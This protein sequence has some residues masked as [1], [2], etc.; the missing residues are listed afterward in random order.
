MANADSHKT[1]Q[2]LHHVCRPIAVHVGVLWL[3]GC[4]TVGAAYSQS[5]PNPRDNYPAGT[6]EQ[7]AA[8][9]AIQALPLD[10]L[11]PDVARNIQAVVAHPTVF[12]RLPISTIDCDRDLFTFLIRN[13]EV[14]I[15][16]WDL[17]GVTQV[18][19]QRTGE[20]RFNAHDGMGT[21]SEIDLVYG[22]PDVHLYYGKGMYE[23][24][25]FKAK[26]FGQ[27]VMLLRTISY[28]AGGRTMVR[29]VL[30]VFLKLDSPA[31]DLVARTFHPLF[32]KAADVNFVET[33]DF[34]MKLSKTAELNPTGVVEMAGRLNDVSPQVKSEFSRLVEGVPR[35]MNPNRD[36]QL[37]R[38]ISASEP[39]RQQ[40]ARM[41][42]QTHGTQTS[43]LS[44][45]NEYLR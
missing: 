24:T 29:N 41:V 20:F 7:S 10:R 13:P 28:E 33:A 21:A 22:T 8:A 40:Q 15:S 23:G 17:M 36:G 32:V 30:D 16:T 35:R 26:V 27:C 5:R 44:R 39:T 34:L 6:A 31:I 9:E 12:R 19:L 2:R 4:V 42:R 37:A 1:L 14:V 38:K 25:L 18:D 43:R 45:P 3:V 11:R